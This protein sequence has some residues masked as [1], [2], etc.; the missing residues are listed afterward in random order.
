MGIG[1]FTYLF[2]G[3]GIDLRFSISLKNVS[4]FIEVYRFLNED[5]Q[6]VSVPPLS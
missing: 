1:Y 2:T 5:P 6:I 3:Q 4:F